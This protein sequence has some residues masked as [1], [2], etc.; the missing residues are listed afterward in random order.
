MLLG[1]VFRAEL[2][3]TARRRH[4]YFLRVVYGFALLLLFWVNFQS[5]Q[6]TTAWRGGR[7]LIE[8]FAAFA[9]STFVW[10]MGV[11]LAT[12]LILVPALFGGVIADEKQRKVMHYLMASRLSSGEIVLDKLAAR[13]LHVG[14]FILLGL[15]VLS[16][17]TL[18]GGVAWEYV[19]AAYLATCSITFF[20]ASLAVL[21]STFARR[22]RQAVL[23]AYLLEIAWLIIPPAADPIFRFLFPQAYGWFEPI[24][25]VAQASNPLSVVLIGISFTGRIRA[26]ALA[27]T[28][29][30]GT[31]LLDPF[32]WMVGL[33][34]A[35]GAFFLLI[36]VWQL[37]PT[38]RRQEESSRRLFG[39]VSRL[40][41]PR[42]LNRPACGADAMLWKERQFARTDVFTSFV[43]LPATILL[44]VCVILG[45]EFD[46]KVVHSF[47]AVWQ[48][49]YNSRSAAPVLLNDTLCAYSP[50]YIALWLLAVA[51]ASACGVTVEREQGTWDG[52]ISSPLTGWEILRGKAVGAIWGL[53]GFG[54]LLSLFWLVGLAAGAVHPLGLLLALL[55]VGLLTWFVV[56]LGTHASLKAR[57]TSRALTGTIVILLSLN[58]GYFGLLIPVLTM[59][60]IRPELRWPV[61][62]CTPLL[63]SD[64]LLSYPHVADLLDAARTPGR[65]L[66]VDPRYVA[67][68]TMV[69]IGYAIAATLL[70]RRLVRRFDEAVDRPW[71]RHDVSNPRLLS[72][73]RS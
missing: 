9:F 37:R 48:F 32:L 35:A 42:W 44:T 22:V 64:S 53:R 69:L 58:A 57:T 30:P 61:M 70:T 38:F 36:A 68:A 25:V 67:Y 47:S 54:G 5:L 55:I 23:I 17:L 41:R 46:E 20:S 63:A 16:L 59:F 65:H 26:S 45:G 34:F 52:L 27:A 18:F 10:F 56:A 39:F 50:L 14:V 4:Y 43:V 3:R 71:R 60:D 8:D 6:T 19:L 33:Q 15:P 24:S 13:L 7:P 73:G 40:R 11:Q 1:P 51:G 31:S 62:G 21:I 72:G 12:I 2:I 28:V 49:G 29:G 66:D